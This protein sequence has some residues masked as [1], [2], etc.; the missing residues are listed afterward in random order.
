MKK[1]WAKA[2]IMISTLPRHPKNGR[3]RNKVLIIHKNQS[4][5]KCKRTGIP[6]ISIGKTFHVSRTP[7]KNGFHATIPVDLFQI[8]LYFRFSVKNTDC[9]QSVSTDTKRGENI[10]RY[11][12]KRF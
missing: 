2:H 1:K 7:A 6:I 12:G 3:N 10:C 9:S 5:R 11:G 4:I 8:D